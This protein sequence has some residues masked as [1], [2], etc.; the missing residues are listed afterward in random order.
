MP[1][2]IYNKEITINGKKIIGI[3]KALSSDIFQANLSEDI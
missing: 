3:A 2:A 1:S